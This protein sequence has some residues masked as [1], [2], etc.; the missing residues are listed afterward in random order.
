MAPDKFRGTL[1]AVEV[2]AAMAEGAA[3]AGWDA[4]VLPMGD[5]GEGSI[6]ILGGPNMT[7]VVCGP[8]GS[9]VEAGW[10]LVERAAVIEMSLASGLNLAG[11][12]EK[13]DPWAATTQGTGQLIDLAI[14]AG[15]LDVT[16]CV[17]GSATTD[18]GQG[19]V[20]ALGGIPFAQ[21][22]TSVRVACDVGTR[23][24]DA[25]AVFGPQKGAGPE[26]VEALAQ[27]LS[28][29]RREYIRR[30]GVDPDQV[31]GSGAAGGLAGALAVLGAVLV[32]GFELLAEVQGLDGALLQANAVVSGEGRL[33]QTSLAGKV[34]GG[35]A[36]KAQVKGLPFL[37]VVGSVAPGMGRALPFVSLAG[38]YGE[39]LA[40]SQ[41]GPLISKEVHRWLSSQAVG[42]GASPALHEPD[43]SS[44]DRSR[45]ADHHRRHTSP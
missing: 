20:D 33:D 29:V 45:V 36:K 17:G 41:P 25:A 31:P 27:R 21:R 26:L 34:V 32:P 44:Q 15:A 16:V 22:G 5:G 9:P 3:M 7:A 2:A 8:L 13:N 24:S 4:V 11:G 12:A 28:A 42:R 18:G 30:Y 14:Q 10:R 19:A 43:F 6:D 40:W 37:A 35:V 23:F 38:A 39:K 1:S